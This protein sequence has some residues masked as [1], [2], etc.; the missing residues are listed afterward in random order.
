MCFYYDWYHIQIG[1][2]TKKISLHLAID[3]TTSKLLYLL[4]TKHS[5]AE[6][7]HSILIAIKDK[8]LTEFGYIYK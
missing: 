5:I 3:N 1:L 7:C 4:V 8:K 6:I 2:E